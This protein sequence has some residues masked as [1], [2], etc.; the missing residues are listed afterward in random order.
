MGCVWSP[1]SDQTSC[2]DSPRLFERSAQ[3]GVSYAVQPMTEHRR[4]PGGEAAGTL[5]VGR[6]CFGYF[7]FAE[8]ES[9]SPAGARP[10]QLKLNAQPYKSMDQEATTKQKAAS[11]SSNK[12]KQLSI[13]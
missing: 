9:N 13:Q 2:S 4:L 3:R 11:R 5:A 6:L 7:H 8:N 12:R 1:K 10:G